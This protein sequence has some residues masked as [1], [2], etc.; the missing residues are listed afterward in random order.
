MPPTMPPT[1]GEAMNARGGGGRRGGGGGG[2]PLFAGANPAVGA[3]QQEMLARS[4]VDLLVE[5]VEPKSWVQNGGVFTARFFGG[6]LVVNQKKAN[7]DAIAQ[8]LG[9]IRAD[10]TRLVTVKAHWVLLAPQELE[11]LT[12]K[13]VGKKASAAQEIDAA[14]LGKLGEKTVH[15]RAQT[16]CFSGQTVHVASGRARTAVTK[17]QA[18]IGNN[19]GLYNPE[20]EI[21]Q[22]GAMLQI[23]PMLSP[24]A[25]Q[26]VVDVQ[27]V[28]TEWDTPPPAA[29]R[30]PTTQPTSEMLDR[31]NVLVQ[32]M[33]TTVQVPVGKPVLV[34]GMTFEP[35][36]K[37]GN[38]PQMY[39]IIEVSAGN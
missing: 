4:V 29:I 5:T 34:G 13:D 19:T 22:A 31:M 18:V 24:D 38:S 6:M 37:G 12:G 3:D 27:S 30:T 25:A 14:A 9:Q 8:L 15:Y 21:V 23:T 20:A 7:H 1:R 2:G 16:S 33:R 10:G 35:S 39:L 26:A 28:V 36:T 17:V 32:Q 11:G